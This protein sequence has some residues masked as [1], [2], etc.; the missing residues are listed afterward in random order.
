MDISSNINV[1]EK[2]IQLSILWIFMLL[3]MIFRDLHEFLRP[4]FLEGIIERN[5]AGTQVSEE[6]LLFAGIMIEIPIAM[7]FLSALLKTRVNR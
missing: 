4:G 5:T 3:N 1:L 2:K 6:L 7:I